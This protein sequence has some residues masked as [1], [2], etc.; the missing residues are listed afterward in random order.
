M[1]TL[2]SHHGNLLPPPL[3]METLT[4]HH[5]YLNLSPWIPSPLVMDTRVQR[6]GLEMYA[7]LF[8]MYGMSTHSL[9]ECGFCLLYAE[10]VAPLVPHRDYSEACLL[11]FTPQS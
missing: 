2:T 8:L 7:M 11:S 1:E 5:G 3:T 4:S 6:N 9:I 10:T